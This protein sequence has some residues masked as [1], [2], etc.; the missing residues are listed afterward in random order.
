M[1]CAFF[2]DSLSN[3]NDAVHFQN[4]RPNDFSRKLAFFCRRGTY[5]QNS[6]QWSLANQNISRF[7]LFICGVLKLKQNNQVLN[8]EG[9]ACYNSQGAFQQNKTSNRHVASILKYLSTPLTGP[10]L[11]IGYLSTSEILK[12]RAPLKSTPLVIWDNHTGTDFKGSC[13]SEK[14]SCLPHH[15]YQNEAREKVWYLYLTR[16][17]SMCS[18]T[19]FCTS[20]GSTGVCGWSAHSACTGNEHNTVVTELACGWG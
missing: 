20:S 1:D 6:L 5:L 4:N 7:K 15:S 3:L 14:S 11:C 16:A 17:P 19:W 8:F 18:V 10:M 12:G 9:E 13:S 2:R